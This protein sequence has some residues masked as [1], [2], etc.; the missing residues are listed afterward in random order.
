VVDLRITQPSWGLCRE[1][2]FLGSIRVRPTL[3]VACERVPRRGTARRKRTSGVR[4]L[5]W[6]AYVSCW[7]CF[8]VQ[9]VHQFE[10]SRLSDMSNLLF[11]ATIK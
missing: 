5:A 8:L 4:G 1:S 3:L 7:A 9:G 6:E 2:F 10:S 11:M